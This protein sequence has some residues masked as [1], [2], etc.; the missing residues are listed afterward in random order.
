MKH[1]LNHQI[2][3]LIFFVFSIFLAMPVQAQEETDSLMQKVK[4]KAYIPFVI[5]DSV[6]R[7]NHDT[8]LYLPP[9][10]VNHDSTAVLQSEQ[11]YQNLQKTL[12]KR[13]I[14]K[15]LS[16]LLLRTQQAN[17]GSDEVSSDILSTG[18]CFEG[19]IVRSITY[20]RLPPFGAD[21]KTPDPIIT[22]RF[23]KYANGIHSKTKERVIDKNIVFNVG[24]VISDNDFSDS[25]RILRALSFIKDA[26]I[27]ACEVDNSHLDIY[28]LTQDQW[29]I[30]I[31]GNYNGFNDFE[32][33]LYNSNFVGTGQYVYL[34][35]VVKSDEPEPLGYN[36]EYRFQNIYGTFIDLDINANENYFQSTWGMNL[37]KDFITSNT[38]TAG[39][40]VAD[41][42]ETRYG[43]ATSDSAYMDIDSTERFWEPL[44]YTYFNSWIGR[45]MHLNQKVNQNITLSGSIEKLQFFQRPEEV[46]PDTLYN[47]QNKSQYAFS[48]TIN[49]R[50]Y[51][52][53]KYLQG[54]GRTEDVPYGW[55]IS[56]TGGWEQNEY[57]GIRPY[58]GMAM[59]V[60]QFTPYGF[61]K[62]RGEVGAF[63]TE[64]YRQETYHFNFQYFSNL[65]AVK[66]NYFRFLLD[67]DFMDGNDRMPGDFLYFIDDD[68]Y[69]DFQIN[70][71]TK[72]GTKRFQLKQENVWFTPL[73]FY[74]FKFAVYQN[75]EVGF[76]TDIEGVSLSS[77]NLF[78]SFGAGVRTRNENLV[79]NTLTLDL[80]YF[81]NANSNNS[82]FQIL[83]TTQIDLPLRDFKPTKPEFLRFQ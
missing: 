60:G 11:F 58:L 18:M 65:I 73:F 22:T 81:P 38:K 24:D 39:A 35:I 20:V 8:T 26:L 51:R 76:L 7:F 2:I 6:Y 48:L 56:T 40:L 54:F 16:N 36:F 55:L 34:G 23:T 72:K 4:V 37:Y 27:Y 3:K 79:F 19:K 9:H 62:L 78:S 75:I 74:G 41:Y 28:V 52:K 25:E 68:V 50:N 57:H 44:E 70:R 67:I 13:R 63:L 5:G 15:E 14:T 31:D 43:Y 10:L 61:F 49:E 33:G 77:N 66:D 1:L 69:T 83:L 21:V 17:S 12:G 47:Y 42:S 64:K 80:K 29:T 30:G 46:G 53:L 32:L 71:Y 82:P 45:S 59:D